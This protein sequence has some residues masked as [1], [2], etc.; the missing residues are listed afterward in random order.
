MITGNQWTTINI[1]QGMR[2][3][4]ALTLLTLFALLSFRMDAAEE[5]KHLFLLS[6]QSNMKRF[7]HKQFFIPAVH[8][9]YGAGNVIVIKNAEGGQPISMWRKGWMSSNGEMPKDTGRLYDALIDRIK[10]N[11]DGVVIKSVTLIWMQG[12]ADAKA[13][14]VDVYAR[15]FR[16]ILK[17]LE[18]DLSRNDINVIIGRLSDFGIKRRPNNAWKELR[19]VQMLL[20]DENPRAVWIDTDDL[21]CEQDELHYVKPDGYRTLGER[22]VEAAGKLIEKNRK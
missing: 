8:A 9:E 22:Y 13:G 15:S 17:Q 12:E 19:H 10:E 14:H 2:V 1:P 7:Q 3:S 20:A 5:G 4:K 11:T 6:G 16:G 18:K 21:N